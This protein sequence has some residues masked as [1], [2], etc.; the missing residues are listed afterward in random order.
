M[1]FVKFKYLSKIL[2][3]IY[4]RTNTTLKGYDIQRWD[5]SY[6]EPDYKIAFRAVND[7]KYY[8]IYIDAEIEGT[9]EKEVAKHFVEKLRLDCKEYLTQFES[10]Q[11]KI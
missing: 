7:S 6:W 4:I 2:R 8:S 9:D 10:K 11:K 3:E 1:S 5:A